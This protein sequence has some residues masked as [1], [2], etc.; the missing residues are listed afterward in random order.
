MEQRKKYKHIIAVLSVCVVVLMLLAAGLGYCVFYLT[1]H[2]V[3]SKNIM[4]NS[5]WL[6]EQEEKGFFDYPTLDAEYYEELDSRYSELATSYAAM[7]E[8]GGVYLQNAADLQNSM[9]GFL[10]SVP[11]VDQLAEG[12][13]NGCEAACA[14]MLMQYCG[15]DMHLSEFVDRFLP[16]EATRL[17]WGCRY[18]P[19]PT[20]AYAGDPRS[21]R[22]GFGCYAPVIVE[23]LRKALPEKY[24]AVDMTGMELQDLLM[25]YVS[26]G[27]P[28][29]VWVTQN[30]E[31]IAEAYQWQS[32]DQDETFLYPVNQHCMVL[33]GYDNT[34][35]Y[36]MDPL[37]GADPVHYSYEETEECFASLGKQAVA[38]FPNSTQ[39]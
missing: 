24:Q 22:G 26:I 12:F 32:Y 39:S 10:L 2:N 36:F 8:A 29:A 38:I 35:Y 27:I 3:F 30:M 5:T 33:C 9:D 16:C 14:V 31:P 23:A 21:Q 15:Q 25:L 28:V 6:Q 7:M 37:G 19:D 4:L 20:K 11:Y 18:G 34:G 13:P 17:R 1:N